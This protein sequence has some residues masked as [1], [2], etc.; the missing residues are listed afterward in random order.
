[1]QAICSAQASTARGRARSKTR[2]DAGTPCG[3]LPRV[4]PANPPAVGN[5]GYQ[6]GQS[7]KD[8]E[9][10]F[11]VWR[12]HDVRCAIL[13]AISPLASPDVP[14]AC[15]AIQSNT[16]RAVGDQLA[17]RP[18]RINGANTKPGSAH[19]RAVP[20]NPLLILDLLALFV[21]LFRGNGGLPNAIRLR[22][23]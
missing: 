10:A 7:P 23:G 3:P 12:V 18:S 13:K 1:M 2:S 8:R 21:N 5:L 11:F 4:R 9:H 16:R 22:P 19:G 17:P 14:A 15:P 20:Q 6:R